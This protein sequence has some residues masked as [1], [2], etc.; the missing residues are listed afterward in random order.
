MRVLF[1]SDGDDMGCD[2]IVNGPELGAL[3]RVGVVLI[4]LCVVACVDRG[5]STE[6]A[7]G[8]AES[9]ESDTDSGASASGPTGDS[10]TGGATDAC[11]LPG[12]DIE[13]VVC[14]HAGSRYAFDQDTLYWMAGG[15][16]QFGGCRNPYI[17]GETRLSKV[18]LDGGEPLRIATWEALG[19]LYIGA[20]SSSLIVSTTDAVW[21]VDPD[22]EMA[23]VDPQRVGGAAI[24]DDTL[25]WAGWDDM[26]IWRTSV[27]A[28]EEARE[29]LYVVDEGDIV[30]AFDASHRGVA[31][32]AGS[33][34]RLLEPGEEEP[35]VIAEAYA[36]GLLLREDRVFWW[37]SVGEAYVASLDDDEPPRPLTE[38][39]LVMAIDTDGTDVYS[40]EWNHLEDGHVAT[41]IVRTS[42]DD[43]TREELFVTQ[44]D[45]PLHPS[46]LGL[47][48]GYLYWSD[49]EPGEGRIVRRRV[50][51]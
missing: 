41:A 1:T 37:R 4:P 47:H 3:A 8:S 39:V 5:H 19:P 26:T 13:V 20:G 29:A 22:G 6:S 32:G 11:A 45:P 33:T 44:P 27:D 31:W 25:Y 28:L 7:G 2:G 24:V 14:G 38:G 35:R 30:F 40:A 12:E 15:S 43:G 23:I 50:S 48:E 42:V 9:G 21:S 36:D 17:C 16:V 46:A 18:R 49:A 51:P 10:A 34:I